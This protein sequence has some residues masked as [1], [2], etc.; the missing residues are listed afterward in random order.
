MKK[1]ITLFLLL[2]VAVPFTA[3]SH[4]MTVSRHLT[5]TVRDGYLCRSI[6]PVVV[7][8]NKNTRSQVVV[9]IP[10][11]ATYV[12][13]K[14]NNNYSRVRYGNLKGYSY[15]IRTVWM[16][17]PV[18][19]KRFYLFNLEN[20]YWPAYNPPSSAIRGGAAATERN[21]R[22]Q[23]QLNAEPRP[24]N[25]RVGPERSSNNGDRNSARSENRRDNDRSQEQSRAD[26]RRR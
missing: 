7:Y 8:K 25:V 12:V 21:P 3:C 16:E 24:G 10:P 1:I 6:E 19:V 15:G 22:R 5:Y 26:Q 13:E 4:R 20:G 17:Q 9:V 2:L 11:G 23:R 14:F 18:R